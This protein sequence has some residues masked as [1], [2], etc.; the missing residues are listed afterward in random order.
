M[1]FFDKKSMR[2]LCWSP[3]VVHMPSFFM[4][5]WLPDTK[6]CSAAS[7]PL[8]E[9]AL[10]RFGGLAADGSIICIMVGSVSHPHS[11]G[12]VGHGLRLLAVLSRDEP[13]ANM[14]HR[15]LVCCCR[16]RIGRQSMTGLDMSATTNFS[17]LVSI[18]EPAFSGLLPLRVHESTQCVSVH[19]G[20]AEF[21]SFFSLS[22]HW[23]RQEQKLFFTSL[24]WYVD[25]I[26]TFTPPTSL[27]RA[28]M[29]SLWLEVF[30]ADSCT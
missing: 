27:S 4:C 2:Y 23:C 5:N 20:I 10:L 30:L 15:I 3:H 21:D 26:G 29:F 16:R 9:T 28:M 24:L 6:K 11:F 22:Q 25:L 7:L 13:E 17:T 19:T 1:F 12:V 8:I 18:T 14:W